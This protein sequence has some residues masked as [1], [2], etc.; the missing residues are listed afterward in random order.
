M[1]RKLALV[2]IGLSATIMV[3]CTQM[4]TMENMKKMEDFGLGLPGAVQ[5]KPR[6]SDA[7]A[8]AP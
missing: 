4:K 1:R 5:Q 6:T 2:L 8:P 3:G 7:P